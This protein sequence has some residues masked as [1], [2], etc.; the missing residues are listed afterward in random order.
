MAPL[1]F[2]PAQLHQRQLGLVDQPDA[3][4]LAELAQLSEQRRRC[5]TGLERAVRLGVT[6]D[7]S[8]QFGG[9][10]L[11]GRSAAGPSLER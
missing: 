4:V 3:G 11:T 8:E 7:E 9:Q 2:S 10:R 5:D 6:F 1:D